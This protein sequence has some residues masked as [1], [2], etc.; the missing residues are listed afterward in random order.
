MR[1]LRLPAAALL[2]A[3]LLAPAAAGAADYPPA[4]AGPATQPKPVGPFRTLYVC[5]KK[6]KAAAKRPHRRTQPAFTGAASTQRCDYTK[7]NDAVKAARPGDTVKVADGTY[8][9]GVI[10]RGA[11]KRYLKLVGNPKAPDKVR[12]EGGSLSGEQAQNGIAVNGANGVTMDGFFAENFAG[13]GFFAVNVNG[14]VMRHLKAKHDGTYGLYA[15]NSIGGEMSDS[16][17]WWHNDSGFYIGQ[18]PPQV[19]PVRTMVRRVKGYENVLGWSGTNM[20][21]V[22]IT[23]SRFYNNGAGVVPNNL[24]SEKYTPNEDNVITGNEI[25]FNDFN[26]YLG[27]PFTL[28]PTAAGDIPFPVGVGVLVFG[29][30]RNRVFD[31]KV[32]GQYLTGLGLI[33]GLANANAADGVLQANQFKGNVM[34]NGGANRNGRDLFYDGSGVGN[35]MTDNT[36]VQTTVPATAST[37]TEACGDPFKA[38]TFDPA[39]QAEA[40]GWALNPDHEAAWIKYPQAPYDGITPMTRY[41]P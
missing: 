24:D 32:F 39:A 29:G 6:P 15:F 33:Q 9:E 26:Y 11:S 18:T 38:N 7:I 27:A 25:F 4:P 21:Y 1:A 41:T 10:V 13:N 8:K 3:A 16:E 17:A 23:E 5:P 31:N 14:Y 20:R 12:L 19:K 36:A 40:I 37:F 34:G 35:C 22:T 2:A 28:R 30:R